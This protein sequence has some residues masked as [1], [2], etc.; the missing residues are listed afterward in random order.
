M[1][2]ADDY[3]QWIVAN[4]AKKGTPEFNTV[5]QADEVAAKLP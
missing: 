2:N 4:Q 3:A 5:A 1:A